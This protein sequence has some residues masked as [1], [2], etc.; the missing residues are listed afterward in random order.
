MG[1][2]KKSKSTEVF[3]RADRSLNYICYCTETASGY[4]KYMYR[5]CNFAH[6]IIGQCVPAMYYLRATVSTGNGRAVKIIDSERMELC[7]ASH[8]IL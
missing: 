4:G 3:V 2:K 5:Y 1:L 7:N 8:V 6:V